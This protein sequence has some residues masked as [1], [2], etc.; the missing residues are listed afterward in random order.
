MKDS[1]FES[2]VM[3]LGDS[4]LTLGMT[5]PLVGRGERNGDSQPKFE[6]IDIYQRI[7]ISFPSITPYEPVILSVSEGSPALV[8]EKT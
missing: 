3:E 2:I 5:E 8:R 1:Y 6:L 4:S 7:A